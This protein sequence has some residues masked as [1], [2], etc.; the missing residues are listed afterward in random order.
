MPGLIALIVAAT[1]ALIVMSRGHQEAP[2][3]PAP[4]QP[5]PSAPSPAPLPSPPPAPPSD[6]PKYALG[7]RYDTH[8][9]PVEW[10]DYVAEGL[11]AYGAHLMAGVSA[12][13]DIAKLCPGYFKAT[14]AQ[15]KAFWALFVASVAGPES[16]Y[17][18]TSKFLEHGTLWSLGPLQLS[19]EDYPGHSRCELRKLPGSVP[20]AAKP[21]DGNAYDPRINIR[22]GVSI[23]DDQVVKGRG[24]FTPKGAGA[25]WSV[26]YPPAAKVMKTWDTYS[27]QLTFCPG[28]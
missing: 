24:L 27:N 9:W 1:L 10:N 11:D 14:M 28:S 16:G 22:C 3:P 4:S 21:A 20:T 13:A 25:Y 15:K 26:L 12:Q 23:L 18:A 19:Y 5:V 2:Q 6:K 17:S 8:L 7:V